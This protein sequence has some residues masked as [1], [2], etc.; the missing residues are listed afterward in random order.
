MTK[1][2]LLGHFRVEAGPDNY[3]TAPFPSLSRLGVASSDHPLANQAG[4]EILRLGGNA[5]DATIGITLALGFCCPYY[6]GIGGGGFVLLWFPGWDAPRCLDY[7]EIAP[8]RAKSDMFSNLSEFQTPDSVLNDCGTRINSTVGGLAAGVP[9]HLIGWGTLH[10]EFGQLDWSTLV[11]AVVEVCQSGVV[12]NANYLRVAR[13][14][15]WL[16]PKDAEIQRVFLDQADPGQSWSNPDLMGSYRQ[17]ADQGWQKYYHGDFARDCVAASQK[18]GGVLEIDDFSAYRPLWREPLVSS[19][20]GHQVYALPCPS[21]GGHQLQA[22]LSQIEKSD[23]CEFGTLAYSD[24]LARCMSG[25]F[26][27][28]SQAGGY[29]A[30]SPGG[31]A[32]FGVSTFDRGVVMATESVNLWWG[33]GV[34]PAGR[35]YLLN[36]VMDDFCCFPGEPDAFGLFSVGNEIRPGQRPASSSCPVIAIKDALPVY[37][38][39]SAGGS[40]IPTSVLQLLLNCIDGQMNVQQSLESTRLHHQ[41]RPDV[42]WV[43]PQCPQGVREALTQMG[44]T[45]QVEEC[46]SHA[47]MTS[48]RWDQRVLTAGGDFRSGGAGAAL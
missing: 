27:R 6:T 47:A 30:A 41:W 45:V 4:L 10:Q 3:L 28:R 20:R 39:G 2:E 14:K 19:F 7:R 46:R 12:L 13:A 34:V 21:Q 48:L 1:Q 31:T 8:R 44:H 42:L 36:N 24:R 17:L 9:S 40:R 18:S 29:G 25:S 37:T 26:E 43:E 32:A 15:R 33:S 23:A 16:F 5:V 11:H 38:A 22:I 35:G